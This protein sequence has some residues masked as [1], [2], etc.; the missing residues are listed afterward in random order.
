MRNDKENSRCHRNLE[1]VGL[2]LINTETGQ[3]LLL[4]VTKLSDGGATPGMTK[5]QDAIRTL[6]KKNF[7]IDSEAGWPQLLSVT[8]PGEGGATPRTIRIQ[9]TIRT[10]TTI[11]KDKFNNLLD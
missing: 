6:N 11:R 1:Q 4:S 3:T 10:L 2:P 8:E 7:F 5:I 9:D